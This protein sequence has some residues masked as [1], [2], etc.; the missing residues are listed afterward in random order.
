MIL[1]KHRSVVLWG[2]Y[3]PTG[4]SFQHIWRHFAHALDRLDKPY[5]WVPDAVEWREQIR[6]GDLVFAVDVAADNLGAPVKGADYLLHNILPDHPV[7][8]GLEPERCVYLQVWTNDCAER[9]EAWGPVRRWDRHSRVLYQPWGTDLLPDEFYPPIYNPDSTLATFVGSV[10]DGNGQ[11]NR[12]A[13]LELRRAVEAHG[14][15]FHHRAGVD[16]RT[17]AELVRMA[18]IAPAVAGQWQVDHEYLPCRVFKNVSYGALGI[19][20]VQKFRQILGWV[21][22]GSISQ[23]V[24]AALALDEDDYLGVVREQQEEVARDY[25]YVQSL[26]AI[27]RAFDE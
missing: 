22:P 26:E 9:G 13:I 15:E 21:V 6:P 16:D 23:I 11:G 19:T 12:D 18:R 20:N 10:W 14:L 27:E 4:D 8:D 24:N 5:I 3:E 7:R 1:P 17:N 25:T 2:L